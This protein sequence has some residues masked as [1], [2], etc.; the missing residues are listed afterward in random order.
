MASP[1]R[2]TRDILSLAPSG[3]FCSAGLP[4]ADAAY[5]AFGSARCDHR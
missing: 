4:S 3:P 2:S 1:A 5:G